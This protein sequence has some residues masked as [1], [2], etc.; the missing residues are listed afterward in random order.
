MLKIFEELKCFNF[1]FFIF[2]SNVYGKS[3]SAFTTHHERM[4]DEDANE[5]I[6]GGR[7]TGKTHV[8][9]K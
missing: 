8:L 7:G 9:G 3:N 6:G 4:I 2:S 5:S 1:Q